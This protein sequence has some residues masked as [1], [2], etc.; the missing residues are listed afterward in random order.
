MSPLH[1]SQR[2]HLNAGKAGGTRGPGAK[3]GLRVKQLVRDLISV[4]AANRGVKPGPISES[5]RPA[6]PVVRPAARSRDPSP[7]WGAGLRPVSP[8]LR[9]G[10][11][12]GG[13]DGPARWPA[14]LER[15]APGGGE[16]G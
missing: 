16:T 7:V 15:P 13:D 2:L 12:P 14:Q 1:L 10:G 4:R 5:P 3:V 11:E 8:P 6:G 9:N